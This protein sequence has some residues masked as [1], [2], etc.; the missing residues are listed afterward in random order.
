MVV[1]LETG[2]VRNDSKTTIE[3][4]VISY[5]MA[6]NQKK[7]EYSWNCQT[8]GEFPGRAEGLLRLIILLFA[9]AQESSYVRIF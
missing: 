5:S 7:F 3:L 4:L 6:L 9:L 8:F 1:G 2:I